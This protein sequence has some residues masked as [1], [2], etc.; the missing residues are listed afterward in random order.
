LIYTHIYTYKWYPII[1]D[2]MENIE[3]YH[4]SIEKEIGI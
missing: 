2:Y 1:S 3:I 4:L